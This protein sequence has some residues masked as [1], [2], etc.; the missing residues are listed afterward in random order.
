MNK[1]I[2][3]SNLAIAVAM[4]SFVGS[5]AFAAGTSVLMEEVLVTAEKRSESVQDVSASITALSPEM[6]ARSGIDDVTRLEHV[7][8][9]MRMGMSGNEAR[10]AIRGTR[11][12]NVGTEG[13]QTVGIFQDGVYVATSMLLAVR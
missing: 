6:M 11:S 2:Q 7:V 4:A 5:S 3:S 1:K 13:E 12:N 10:I 8:P 9:G